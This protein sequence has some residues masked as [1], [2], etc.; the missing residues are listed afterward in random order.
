MLMSYPTCIALF[1]SIAKSPMMGT[2]R[3]AK[4]RANFRPLARLVKFAP[5]IEQG[6]IDVENSHPDARPV[7]GRASRRAWHH[8]DVHTHWAVG[9]IFG[10]RVR[11][12][13]RD[14]RR[15]RSLLQSRERCWRDQRSQDRGALSRRR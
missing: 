11:A 7:G 9:G 2:R 1:P 8:A 12:W 14:A 15:R 10:R 13:N 6:P 5:R 4:W 3:G